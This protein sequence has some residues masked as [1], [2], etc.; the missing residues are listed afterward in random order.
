MGLELRHKLERDLSL[1]LSATIIWNYPTLAALA[2]YLQTCLDTTAAPS[3]EPSKS[4]TGGKMGD[5]N[6]SS[7]TAS[8]M[9]TRVGDRLLQV[10]QLTEDAALDALRVSK[11]KGPL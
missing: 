3:V 2:R 10:E 1:R 9:T 8:A 7:A 5:R 6:P 4:A 11:S